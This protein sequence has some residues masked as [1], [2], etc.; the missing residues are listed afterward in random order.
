MVTLELTSCRLSPMSEVSMEKQMD[1]GSVILSVNRALWGEISERVYAVQVTYQINQIDLYV[2]FLKEPTD[3]DIESSHVVAASIAADF[4]N[5]K[6]LDH[7]EQIRNH[8]D[9]LK[10]KDRH[11]VFLRSIQEP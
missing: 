8:Q 4:S 7:C 11:L 1:Y 3:L 5:C 10:I 9:F 2:I 6:V